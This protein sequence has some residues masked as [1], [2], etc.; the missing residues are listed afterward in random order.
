MSGWRS[1]GSENRFAVVCPGTY[2]FGRWVKSCSILLVRSM[3]D[4]GGRIISMEERRMKR[5]RTRVRDGG[6]TQRLRLH[7]PLDQW[8]EAIV[9]RLD[10]HSQRA[11][12]SVLPT[13]RPNGTWG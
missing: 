5:V 8:L 13:A 4:G 11:K 2:E 10:I 1:R 12:S 6:L 7:L 3:L 9:R